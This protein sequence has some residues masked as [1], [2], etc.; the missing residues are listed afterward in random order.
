VKIISP[1]SSTLEQYFI[2]V[3]EIIFTNDLNGS[4]YLYT[5]KR[6]TLNRPNSLIQHINWSKEWSINQSIYQINT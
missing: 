4:N 3:G 1:Q 6:M 2:N 5:V